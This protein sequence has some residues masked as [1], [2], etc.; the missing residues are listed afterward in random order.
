MVFILVAFAERADY[1][2]RS[3]RIQLW[4]F[5]QVVLWGA[6]L[7]MFRTVLAVAAWFALFSALL[8]SA[9]RLLGSRRR[10]VYI[11]WFALAAFFVLSGRILTEVKLNSEARTTNL[12]LQ[13]QNIAN[14][15]AGNRLARYGS[16]AVFLPA[17]VVAPFPTMVNV[18]GQENSMMINGSV[19]VHNVYAFF[20]IM[21]IFSIYRK[22]IVTYH[23]LILALLGS[24]LFVLASSGF[25]LS[26]RFHVPAVPFLLILAGYGITQLNK[27]YT[28][29]YI[30]YLIVIAVI[31]IGWN[32][33]KLAGR[34][35]I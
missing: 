31:I 1:M 10:T 13:M 8:F 2:L 18:A 19:F 24:Y 7:F 14:R 34:G 12:G 27:R 21:G 26:E 16:R 20:V 30:P 29:L 3:P 35:L 23:I 15:E 11:T 5:F 22:K 28:A 32:W 6:V 9:G 17:M 25:A 4:I 33:F